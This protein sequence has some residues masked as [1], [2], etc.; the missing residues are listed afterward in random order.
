MTT[1]INV[2]IIR[3]RSS[4][5]PI[6]SQSHRLSLPYLVPIRA[7]CHHVLSR[8]TNVVYDER[9]TAPSVRAGSPPRHRYRDRHRYNHTDMDVLRTL[10]REGS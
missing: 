5:S 7:S 3:A 1:R 2:G 9:L 6:L 8:C 4:L 10:P